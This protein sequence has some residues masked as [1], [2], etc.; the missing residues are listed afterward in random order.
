MLSRRSFFVDGSDGTTSILRKTASA[1]NTPSAAF[2]AAGCAKRKISGEL[3]ITAGLNVSVCQ[4]F[5]AK[6]ARRMCFKSPSC[7][8]NGRA[9]FDSVAAGWVA[10]KSMCESCRHDGA[11]NLRPCCTRNPLASRNTRTMV[12]LMADIILAQS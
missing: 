10:K 12:S 7:N 9:A 1:P 8:S 6:T 3:A 2:A 5:T 11:P 4:P